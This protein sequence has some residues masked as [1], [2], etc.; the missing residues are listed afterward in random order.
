ME[1]EN[2]GK[3]FLDHWPV[4]S[5]RRKCQSGAYLPH[6]PSM[7][8][9]EGGEIKNVD[10]AVTSLDYFAQSGPYCCTC[11]DRPLALRI[12]SITAVTILLGFVWP[13]VASRYPS[14]WRSRIIITRSTNDL[15]RPTPSYPAC[16]GPEGHPEQ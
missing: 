16:E 6:D 10:S 9:D 8:N 7:S 13:P 2:G 1:T 5:C 15:T 14:P 11:Q 4:T 12:S 3:E